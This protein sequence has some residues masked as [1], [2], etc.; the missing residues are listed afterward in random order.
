M[1]KCV[2]VCSNLYWLIFSDSLCEHM[3]I[4]F[5][6]H[7]MSKRI[8]CYLFFKIIANWALKKQMKK[9]PKRQS[10]KWWKWTCTVILLVSD[11]R[12]KSSEETI[13]NARDSNLLILSC[14]L[15]FWHNPESPE[16]SGC[17]PAACDH[18]HMDSYTAQSLHSTA[19]AA[20]SAASH[21]AGTTPT[22]KS[23]NNRID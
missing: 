23:E 6:E 16:G 2:C 15:G 9:I 12:C 13:T 21:T 22:L 5:I 14:S 11:R 3:S 4:Y 20:C 19:H 1:H 8:F 7:T 17:I 10:P 18:L